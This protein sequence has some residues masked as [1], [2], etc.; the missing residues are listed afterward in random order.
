MLELVHNTTESLLS[1]H[2][3]L[4]RPQVF[5]FACFF[6]CLF[7]LPSIC[8]GQLE[9]ASNQKDF[10]AYSLEGTSSMLLPWITQNNI[11]GIDLKVS[12][13][14]T[15]RKTLR[16]PVRFQMFLFFFFFSLRLVIVRLALPGKE[17]YYLT[18]LL[19]CHKIQ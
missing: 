1:P 8:L 7:C 19:L 5:L 10:R 12:S 15:T 13:S 6:V 9:S 2:L 11:L 17:L 3:E 16:I 18:F 14:I 4:V